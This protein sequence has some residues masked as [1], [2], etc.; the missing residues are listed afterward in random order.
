MGVP[1]PEPAALR[2]V[3]QCPE[4]F[5]GFEHTD[6]IHDVWR[7]RDFDAIAEILR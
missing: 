7:P 3:D 2:F 1:S 4:R 5:R 6:S